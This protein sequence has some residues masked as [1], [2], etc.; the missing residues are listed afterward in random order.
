MKNTFLKFLKSLETPKNSGLLEAVR[1]GHK[2]IFE[3]KR[4][5]DIL[6]LMNT[7]GIPWEEAQKKYDAVENTMKKKITFYPIYM[8][9]LSRDAEQIGYIQFE[10][11]QDAIEWCA[12]RTTGGTMFFPEGYG[13]EIGKFSTK[14]ARR[15]KRNALSGDLKIAA[16]YDNVDMG[17]LGKQY[18]GITRKEFDEL[19]KK[20]SLNKYTDEGGILGYFYAD[21][22]EQNETL[23]PYL[24]EGKK[25]QKM[26]DNA[27]KDLQ[28]FRR[29]GR[30]IDS[31]LDVK[32]KFPNAEI[33][34][35]VLT[36]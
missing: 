7:M 18:E 21:S 25:H 2:I 5:D 14:R 16:E 31:Y 9:K 20:F 17:I 19:G 22:I 34:R 10:S 32:N 24:I 28:A 4:E 30:L 3:A 11:L 6:D 8:Y 23:N 13:D 1:K 36:K 12:D 33:H 35:G 26:A 29:R 15:N 27:I